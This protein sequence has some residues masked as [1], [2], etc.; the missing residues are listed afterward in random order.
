MTVPRDRDVTRRPAHAQADRRER[1]RQILLQILAILQPDRQPHHAVGDAQ[2][3]AF[4]GADAHVRRG[5]RMRHQRFA[6]RRDC[7][8]SAISRSAF[9]TRNAASLPPA[10]SNVTT[11]PPR[12]HL[13]QSPARAADGRRAS[14]TTRARPAGRAARKSAIAAAL[15][16]RGIDPQR[17]RLQPLQQQPGVE[18]RHRRAGVADEGLQ[19][20]VDPLRAAEHRAAEHPALAVDVLGAGIHHHVG[21]ELQRLL[22]QRRGEHVVHHHHARRRRAP[23]PRPRADR[24]SPASGWTAFPAAPPAPAAPAPRATAAGRCHRRTRSRCRSAAAA[25][26]RSSGTSRTARA[27]PPRG[28]RALTWPSSAACTAAM[29]VAV[30]RHASAPSISASRSLQHRSPSGCRSAST[31]NGRSCRRTSPRPARRCRRR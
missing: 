16:A 1:L 11:V 12:G 3:R 4:L 29:P 27:R 19:R 24:R 18:R 14:D 15:R 30:A 28:R 13:R 20:L 7:W 17:Q 23:A 2:P 10:T 22:Q 5:R 8:K 31:G 9:I 26:R 6:N 25:S 21:A